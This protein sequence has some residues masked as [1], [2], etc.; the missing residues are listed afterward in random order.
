MAASESPR[1]DGSDDAHVHAVVAQPGGG[2]PRA[3]TAHI[4]AHVSAAA[5]VVQIVVAFPELAGLGFSQRLFD[6]MVVSADDVDV[7]ADVAVENALNSCRD[8]FAYLVRQSDR[9]ADTRRSWC[10]SI[11]SRMTLCICSS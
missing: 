3:F 9:L 5:F 10:A 1:G 6:L 4:V 7:V 11:Q 2:A 8:G